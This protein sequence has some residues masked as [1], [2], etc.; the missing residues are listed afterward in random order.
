M[1]WLL[2]EDGALKEKLRGLSVT[3]VN[4]PSGRPVP[5]RF[6]LP[7][8][9]LA[10][11]TFPTVIIDHSDLVKD[12]Q[13]EHRGSILLPY[14]PEGQPLWD[15]NPTTYDPAASPYTA[16]FPIPY[17][18]D[19][20]VTVL[21]R[22]V[23]HH[24]S[25]VQQMAAF[26]YLPARFG[27]LPIPEDGTVRRLDLIGGPELRA[28][29]DGDGKRLFQAIYGIRVSTELLASQVQTFTRV[30]EVLINMTDKDSGISLDQFQAEYDIPVVAP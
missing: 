19:Y 10:D 24:M 21:S 27:F 13:R 16:D 30:M 26:D 12:S 5:V 22:K 2:N 20:Q 25:L 28:V 3:D 17:N 15:T 11:L 8:N 6:R 4:A 18:I 23:L 7:E 29:K 14:A 1:S 9:E